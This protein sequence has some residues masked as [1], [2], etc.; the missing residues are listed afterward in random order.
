MNLHKNIVLTVIA[1]S[2]GAMG[3]IVMAQAAQAQSSAGSKL[4]QE[5]NAGVISTDFTNS[6]GDTVSNPSFSLSAV[7]TSTTG[8]MTSTG[9][10]AT[11]TQRATVDNPGAATTFTL[12]LAA[13]NPSIGWYNDTAPTVSVYKHNG[14]TA[15]EG[16]LS[17]TTAG[18]LGTYNS[19]TTTGIT[20]AT[21][22]TF[23]G[24]TP[25]TL[26]SGAAGMDTVWRGYIYGVGLSQ[27]IPQGTPAANYS[28]DL[29]QTVTAS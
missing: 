27:V 14:A 18:T 8:N 19:G 26:M 21:T 9:T 22:G 15:T 17:V 23:T 1:I 7:T 11:S 13:T 6:S 29:T 4:T 20:G 2:I 3:L 10:F 12:T 16:Q 25:I 5:V 28:I 24:A